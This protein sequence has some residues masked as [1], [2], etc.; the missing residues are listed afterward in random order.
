MGQKSVRQ[1]A[2]AIYMACGGL[3]KAD[4]WLCTQ[5]SGHKTVAT[6]NPT[7]PH[8][9]CKSPQGSRLSAEKLNAQC[10]PMAPVKANTCSVIKGDQ[11]MALRVGMSTREVAEIYGEPQARQLRATL[12][13]AVAVWLYEATPGPQFPIIYKD[14]QVSGW[15]AAYLQSISNTRPGY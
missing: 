9:E 2:A 1:V 12:R 14:A 4:T 8:W 6:I 15:G 13:G 3:A 11:T 10:V 7:L 5:P